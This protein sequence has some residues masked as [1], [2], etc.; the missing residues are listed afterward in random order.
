MS[1]DFGLINLV[2]SPYLERVG[3]DERP[4]GDQQRKPK[5]L[6]SKPDLKDADDA[7]P[8]ATQETDDSISSQH[9]DLRI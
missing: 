3:R 5:N 4:G 1:D 8:D 7:A 2:G 6:K 9:V